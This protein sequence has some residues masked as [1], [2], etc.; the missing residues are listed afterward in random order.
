MSTLRYPKWPWWPSVLPLFLSSV[1]FA[2]VV[3]TEGLR[4]F[5]ET[6]GTEWKEARAEAEQIATAKHIAIRKDLGG[7][8]VMELQKFENNVPLYFMDDNADAAKSLNTDDLWSLQGVTGSGFTQLGVW[9]SGKIRTTHQE[10]K[11]RITLGDAPSTFSAHSTHVAGTL[12]ATGIAPNAKGMAYQAKLKAFDWNNDAAEMATAAA[13]GLRISNHSY[14]YVRGWQWNYFLDSKY[15]WFGDVTISA[16]EDYKFGFYDTLCQQWDT[17]EYNAPNYLIVKSAGNDRNDYGPAPYTAHWIFKGGQWIISKATR[18]PDGG[19]WG[20]DTI[21]D[22]GVA[23]NVL[24]VGAVE[25]VLSYTGPESVFM[26]AFSGFGPTDDGRIKPD[27]VADGVSLYSSVS[28]ND[29]SY[30]SYSGTSMA[31]PN[32]AGTLVLLHQYYQKLYGSYMRAATLKALVIHTARETGPTPGPDYAFG[33]GLVNAEKAAQVISRANKD[34]QTYVLQRSL[35]QGTTYK[36]TVN[37]P[38][39]APELRAT[40][41]WTDP[42]GTPPAYAL[43]PRTPMLVNDLDLQVTRQADTQLFSPWMLDPE[44]PSKAATTGNNILDTVEQVVIPQ[45]LAGSYTIQVSHKGSTLV[46][47]VQRYSLLIT[48]Y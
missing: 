24:T 42:A 35:V 8:N 19:T 1:S 12:I 27:V 44:N 30:G 39:G 14:G 47:G 28:T 22:S 40:I 20:Y 33:W 48:M 7:G 13:A 21:G 25:D 5:S 17:I 16:T 43:N 2:Q 41:V 26:S 36:L 15:A 3:N 45:P 38:A 9:D 23:K 18:Q 29:T 10:L 37:V 34:T 32:V 11:G 4:N 6:I 46:G 31:S